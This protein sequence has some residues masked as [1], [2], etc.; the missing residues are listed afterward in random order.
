LLVEQEVFVVQNEQEGSGA[1]PEV[2]QVA[3]LDA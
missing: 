3:P 2:F 1:R